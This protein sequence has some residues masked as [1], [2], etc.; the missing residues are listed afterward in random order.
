ME[1]LGAYCVDNLPI[2]LLPEL[3]K[4]HIRNDQQQLAVSVDIRSRID[5]AEVNKRI[6]FLRR[7]GHQIDILFLEAAEDVLIRRFSETRRGHPLAGL[8]LTLQESL[9]Q[10]RKWLWPL[11]E[12]AYCID[13]SNMNAQ[14]LRCRVQQWLNADKDGMLV[15]LESFGFKYGAPANMDFLFDVRSLPNPYYDLDLRPY[16]GTQKPIQDY[17]SQQE[18]VQKMVNDISHFLHDWLPQMQ[19]ESRSYVTI[20]IGCTGGQHRSV[21]VVEQL[22]AILK[23]NYQL[24]VRHRQLDY[25]NK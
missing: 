18:L 4:Y 19:L 9:H 15:I 13:T 23:P 20:G 10:E 6:Q 12:I 25:P 22:A 17:L 8:S 2:E 11:R 21:Y 16:N 3:V 5:I 7:Q 24:L 14:Q 1:D